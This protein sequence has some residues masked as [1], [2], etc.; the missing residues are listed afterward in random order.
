[1]A[2]LSSLRTVKAHLSS[3]MTKS[4]I[5]E[6]KSRFKKMAGQTDT[7]ILSQKYRENG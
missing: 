1:M 2:G 5:Q 3:T 7:I 6:R 4:E